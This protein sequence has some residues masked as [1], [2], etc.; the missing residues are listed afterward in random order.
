M[1]VVTRGKVH[2]SDC[3]AALT[4]IRFHRCC[5]VLVRLA[6]RCTVTLEV[7]KGLM[8][9]TPSGPFQDGLCQYN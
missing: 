2:C 4:M 9:V 6:G 8:A 1:G 3:W 7:S 5:T